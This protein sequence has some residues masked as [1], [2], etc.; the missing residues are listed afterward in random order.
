MSIA[1][2][3][4]TGN[5]GRY[6]AFS[7]LSKPFRDDFDKV[8]ILTREISKPLIKDLEQA[9]GIIVP[10][11]YESPEVGKLLKEALVDV[12]VVI[13]VQSGGPD[14]QRNMDILLKASVESESVKYYI[15]SQFGVD[16]RFIGEASVGPWEAKIKRDQAARESKKL[17]VLSIYSAIFLE[18]CF[19]PWLG[20]EVEK[21]TFKAVGS[22]DVNL[23]L[24]SKVDVGLSVASLSSTLVKD[25]TNGY[26]FPDHLRISGTQTT[27]NEAAKIFDSVSKNSDQK[28]N[29]EILELGSVKA[30]AESHPFPLNLVKYITL[31]MGEGKLN[32]S[33][34][35]NKLVN[36]KAIWKWTTFEEYAKS[37]NGRPFCQDAPKDTRSPLE[38]VKQK[39]GQLARFF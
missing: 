5:L 15:P 38:Q 32:F 37:V 34:N 33:E 19:A 16:V 18:D 1:I 21:N 9:G 7:C 29:V 27:I 2:A 4:A 26:N 39:L 23:S 20:F 8:K 25:K 36:P 10:I 17:K 12:I 30:E 3:G 6:I 14:A 13:D 28:I 35:E 22:A 24:T 31:F 11:N